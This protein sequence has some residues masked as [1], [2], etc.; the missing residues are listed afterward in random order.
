V[1]FESA[2]FQDLR[3]WFARALQ[4]HFEYDFE[5]SLPVTRSCLR[6]AA[7]SS[8]RLNLPLKFEQA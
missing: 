7:T 6:V 3:L 2:A 8:T 1:T 5:S 4:W